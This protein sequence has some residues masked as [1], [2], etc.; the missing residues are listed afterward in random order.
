M[1]RWAEEEVELPESY[2]ETRVV[3]ML[4]DPSWAFAYWD[5]KDT[6]RR[7]F[8]RSESFEGLMLRVYTMDDPES[9]LG[10]ARQ[11]F[12]IPVTLLDERWYINLP[13]QETYYKLAL[14]AA[15]DGEERS[16]A[17]SNAIVVPRGM[18][19]RPLD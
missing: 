6:D 5:L 12:D 19:Y 11:Q 2:N 14:V 7:D 16:L 1:E 15:A 13:D 17:V 3:L 8:Q 9:G 4:R 18:T 10:D